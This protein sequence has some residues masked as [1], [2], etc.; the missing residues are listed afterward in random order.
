MKPSV[1]PSIT[2]SSP[3]P[4]L[5]TETRTEEEEAARI[6]GLLENIRQ[7]NLREDIDLFMSC[8]AADFKGLEKKKRATLE[9]WEDSDYLDLSYSLKSRA[10]TEDTAKIQVEWLIRTA[11]SA[12]G[13]LEEAELLLEALLK[14]EGDLW[15]IKE[16]K[17]LS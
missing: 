9:S 5:R 13:Q 1:T 14:K 10:L 6:K 3:G 7:A 11:R 15:K 4:E 2:P 16:I 12:T 17:T 8:Y